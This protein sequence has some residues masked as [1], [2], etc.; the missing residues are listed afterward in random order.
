M[1]TGVSDGASRIIPARA[2]FTGA[3]GGRCLCAEDHPRSRGVY[4]GEHNRPEQPGRII[5][6]RAGFTRV[7][8][9]RDAGARDHPR[10]RGVYWV[11][12]CVWVGW[13]GSSPLARGLRYRPRGSGP[14]GRIIPARAGFTMSLPSRVVTIQDHPRSRGV[15]S[16][17]KFSEAWERGS[18]PLARGLREGEDARGGGDGIIPARAGFTPGIRSPARSPWDHPRSRGVYLDPVAVIIDGEGSSPLARGLR[19]GAGG[20][21]PGIGIIPARAGFTSPTPTRQTPCSDHPRSRGVYAGMRDGLGWSTGSSPLARGLR[22][23]VDCGHLWVRIIPARAGFTE[24][25]GFVRAD[26]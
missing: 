3:G 7:W 13:G 15:Y 24:L 9:A 2:G 18:S 5:P 20:Y 10:S 4:Q 19:A 16:T 23:G 6:A 26:H 1:R 8:Y 25:E 17:S 21:A 22:D 14:G 11:R 12:G